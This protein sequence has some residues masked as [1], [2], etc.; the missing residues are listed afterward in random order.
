MGRQ[1]NIVTNTEH[2]LRTESRS[3]ILKSRVEELDSDQVGNPGLDSRQLCLLLD[4]I[5]EVDHDPRHEVTFPP[6]SRSLPELSRPSHQVA[7]RQ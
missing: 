7:E 4:R 5:C 2:N 1:A 6:D 3:F